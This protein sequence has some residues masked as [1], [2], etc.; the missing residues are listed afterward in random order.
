VLLI[1]THIPRLVLGP[2]DDGPDKLLH[3]GAFAVITTL[4]HLAWPWRAWWKTGLIVLGLAILDEV[5]QEIPGLNRS[6]DPLDLV[7]DSG[8][9]AVALAWCAALG[10]P[11]RG[12]D[13]YREAHRR[14]AAGCRLLLASFGN[15][16]HLGVAAVLGAMLFGVLLVLIVR[17]PAIGPITMTVVGAETGLIAGVVAALEI[18]RRHAVARIESEDRCLDCLMPGVATGESCPTCGAIAEA[19]PAGGAEIRRGILLPALG[20]VVL[21][22]VVL[23]VTSVGLGWLRYSLARPW[24]ILVWY[25]GLYVADA[26]ALDAIALGLIGA[27]TIRWRRGRTARRLETAGSRCLRCGH[28][29]RG[30]PD[31]DGRGTCSECGTEF[32]RGFADPSP[33]GEHA[34]S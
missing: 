5:T 20:M 33:S 3:M 17:H 29:L 30:T 22:A 11:T 12:P 27:A 23:L 32:V 28:D 24:P 7:A 26:M 31:A 2:E 16:L 19:A 8:G 34:G 25:D 13:W 1:G 10:P 18:G 15:W 21:A 4:L 9:I 14:R 6:F